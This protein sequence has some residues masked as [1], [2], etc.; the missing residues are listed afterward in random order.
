MEGSKVEVRLTLKSKWADRP[1]NNS[2]AR[3]ALKK[4]TG[5]IEAS[6]D[7][8]SGVLH[9]FNFDIVGEGY[10]IIVETEGP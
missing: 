10:Q 1:I 5:A 9:D 7:N 4:I 3:F 6:D 8:P 2:L